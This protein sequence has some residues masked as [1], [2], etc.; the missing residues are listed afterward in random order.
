M[1]RQRRSFAGAAVVISGAGGGL[2]RALARRFAQAGA[3][4]VGLDRDAAAIQSL[5]AE[6]T[7]AGADILALPCDVTDQEACRA[8]IDAA[9]EHCGRIDVVINNAGLSHRSP[10]ADTDPAVLRRVLDVNLFG[11]IHLTHPALPALRL[12]TL[13][14][15]FGQ[16]APAKPCAAATAV[17][18]AK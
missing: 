2:G 1:T 12:A 18:L 4:I 3:R 16:R 11:A 13:A 7:Q 5:A 8:A 15:I 17:A 6:L 14:A 10:F 9:L